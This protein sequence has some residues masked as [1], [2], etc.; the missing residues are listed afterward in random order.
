MPTNPPSNLFNPHFTKAQVKQLLDMAVPLLTEVLNYGLSVFAR[1]AYRPAGDD[2]NL[3]ILFVYRHLLEMLDSVIIQVAECAPAPAALQLRAM[4]DALLTIEYILEDEG[5]VRER[6]F[7]Y[8]HNV[9][10]ERRRTYLSL[11]PG[12]PQGKAFLDAISGDPYS[13]DHKPPVVPDLAER[14]KEI[15]EMLEKPELK[16]AAQAYQIAK[17]AVGRKPNWYTLYNGPKNLGEL[18]RHLKRGAQYEILYK[19]WAERGHS[20]DAIDRILIVSADGPSARGLRDATELESTIDFAITFAVD[21]ARRLIEHYRSGEGK[22]FAKWYLAEVSLQR[23]ALPKL[24]MER[25]KA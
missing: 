23:K 6:A 18:A 25:N 2:E 17:K 19:E 15:D 9:Q 3:P 14:L 11:D 20:T 4:F 21:A 7:A 12:T 24:I 16:A 22:S 5:K 8:I 1:C 10:L 13:K